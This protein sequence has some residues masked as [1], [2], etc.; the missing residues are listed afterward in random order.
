MSRSTRIPADK[1]PYPAF[2][3]EMIT[4]AIE[5]GRG[6]RK[7]N[8][9]EDGSSARGGGRGHGRTVNFGATLTAYLRS[10]EQS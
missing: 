8:V 7:G 3:A 2:T 4:K 6:L 9:G 5:R 10:A 1:E